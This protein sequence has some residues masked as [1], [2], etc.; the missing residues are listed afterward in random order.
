[1]NNTIALNNSIALNKS[2]A[3]TQHLARRLNLKIFWLLCFVSLS[4]FLGL[5]VFQLNEMAGGL[6]LFEDCQR[7]FSDLTRENKNLEVNF[8][9]TNSLEDIE[10]LVQN[11]NF[12]K[13]DKV[14]YL[15]IFEGGIAA[16]K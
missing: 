8:M 12:E 15:W 4:I 10:T 11:L 7:R 16:N 14:H 9:Q 5:Y 6:Y 13:V 1:M 2:L 3:L